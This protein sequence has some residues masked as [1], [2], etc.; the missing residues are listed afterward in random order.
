LPGYGFLVQRFSVLVFLAFI[1]LGSMLS[2]TR[3]HGMLKACMC[4]AV[5]IHASCWHDYLQEFNTLNRSFSKHFFETC[6]NSKVLTGLIFDNKF[7]GRPIYK[8]CADYYIVWRKGIAATRLLDE[9]SFCLRRA[10]NWEAISPYIDHSSYNDIE[11]LSGISYI[12]VRG[13]IPE[14]SKNLFERFSLKKSA[15]MWS[16]FEVI[17]PDT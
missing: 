16:L 5:L 2:A 8:Q 6:D 1:I 7:R 9:R 17:N 13:E 3:I 12:L 4:C 15:G 14:S 10:T 11:R